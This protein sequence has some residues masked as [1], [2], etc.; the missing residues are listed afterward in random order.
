MLHFARSLLA[1][2]ALEL[3]VWA[4]GADVGDEIVDCWHRAVVEHNASVCEGGRRKG[5]EE[6]EKEREKKN[7][8][9]D[10]ER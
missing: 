10:N 8:R 1:S 4:V 3:V 6:G 2:V 7:N 9:D 5:E